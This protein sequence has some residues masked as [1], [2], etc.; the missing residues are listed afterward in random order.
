MKLIFL[1]TGPAE[2]IPRAGHTDA[3]CVDA[4]KPKSKSRRG[5]SSALLQFED[6]NILIDASPDF[7]A[8]AIREKIEKIDMVLLTH[9]HVDAVG[10]L[11]ELQ[12]WLK[13]R[14]S[15]PIPICG[16]PQ[17][18]SA[19][20]KDIGPK[21][22]AITVNAFEKINFG[23]IFAILIPV[24]HG[25][26]PLPTSGF[27]FE[28]IIFYASDMESMG[29][30]AARA[31][32]DTKTV[33]LDGAFWRK[34]MLRGHLTALETIKLASKLHPQKLLIT[35]SGHTYPPHNM[36]QRELVKIVKKNNCRFAVQL[37]YDGLHLEL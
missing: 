1:G 13:K 4:R 35:Q 23:K 7:L 6:K 27:L 31:V 19:V 37:S 15:S 18:I 9:A 10:G 22:R 21:L 8:Q 34:K 16:Q 20:K 24:R 28:K 14:N 26:R 32:R 17:T 29:P 2:A 12:V 33:I 11:A 30:R 36:A 25:V 3:L 5:R